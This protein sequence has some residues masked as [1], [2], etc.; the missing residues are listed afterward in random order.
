VP[1]PT[2]ENDSG[3]WEAT[4][5]W[6]DGQLVLF[7]A[8]DGEVWARGPSFSDEVVDM[9]LDAAGARLWIVTEDDNGEG[10]ELWTVR[11]R[12]PL[13]AVSRPIDGQLL[14]DA[15]GAPRSRAWIDGRGRVLPIDE[16]VVFFEEGHGERWRFFSGDGGFAPSVPAW[17][18]SSVWF[19]EEVIGTTVYALTHGSL[20]GLHKMRGRVEPPTLFEPVVEDLGAPPSIWPSSARLQPGAHGGLYLAD[21][22]NERVVVARLGGKGDLRRAT[23]P[24]AATRVEQLAVMSRPN[25]EAGLP[26]DRLALLL[27]D[28]PS[29]VVIDAR[30]GAESSVLDN[31]WAHARLASEPVVQ[32]RF[33]GR[34]LIA[35]GNRLLAA[36]RAGVQSFSLRHEAATLRLTRQV[37]FEGSA[38]RGPIVAADG[39]EP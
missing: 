24:V 37:D 32:D 3:A 10:S 20:P 4:L 34:F 18:P 28:P 13:G 14:G 5:G 31:R 26:W 15:F 36:T 9:A 23:L 17:R 27:S 29:L 25:S 11:V 8:A 16:G 21:I 6:R 33:F 2:P 30:P 12:P 38:L 19:R 7:A 1:E 22:E 39:G 35:G